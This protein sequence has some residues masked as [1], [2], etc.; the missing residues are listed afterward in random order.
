MWPALNYVCTYYKQSY[1]HLK[2]ALW[3]FIFDFS[4]SIFKIYL[5]NYDFLLVKDFVAG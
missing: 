3:W 4:N 5:L 2:I 1:K